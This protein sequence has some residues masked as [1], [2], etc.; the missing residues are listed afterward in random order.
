MQGLVPCQILNPGFLEQVSDLLFGGGLF[1]EV[2]VHFRQAWDP[3]LFRLE[4]NFVVDQ[5]L[6]EV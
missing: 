6:F 2:V 3:L 1:L 4:L 5:A